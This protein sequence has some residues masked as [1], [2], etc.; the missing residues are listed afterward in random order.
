MPSIP[1]HIRAPAS[2][3][4]RVLCAVEFCSRVKVDTGRRTS[5]LVPDLVHDWLVREPDLGREVAR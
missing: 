1:A 4:V 3:H 2:Q 5:D